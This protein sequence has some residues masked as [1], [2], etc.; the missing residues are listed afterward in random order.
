MTAQSGLGFAGIV[1]I[2]IPDDGATG[3][4]LTKLTPD[5][6]DYDWQAS[7][8]GGGA[9][10]NAEYVVISLDPTLTDERVLTA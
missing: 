5:N 9:P 7:G 10:D 2:Q 4:V 8:G 3:E 1:A 6:Y